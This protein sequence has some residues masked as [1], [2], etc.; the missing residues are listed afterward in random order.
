MRAALLLRAACASVPQGR[1]RTPLTGCF[2]AEDGIVCDGYRFAEHASAV[3]L[4]AP[5]GK[6]RNTAQSPGFGGIRNHEHE[7]DLFAG[8]V[9]GD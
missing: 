7:Q 8:T 4:C 9:R 2:A 3:A 5:E 1:E 6:L